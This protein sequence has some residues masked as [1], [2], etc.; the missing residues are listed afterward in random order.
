M[1]PCRSGH[2]GHLVRE[3]K[4]NGTATT[5]DYDAFGPFQI[6]QPNGGVTIIIKDARGRP[7]ASI[8]PDGQTRQARYHDGLD[9]RV[10]I[11]PSG[12]AVRSRY[13]G[14]GRLAIAAV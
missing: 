10:E 6:T 3:T 5:Y 8:G 13:D 7:I 9:V 1:G 2:A 14:A 11:L 4:G 12:A